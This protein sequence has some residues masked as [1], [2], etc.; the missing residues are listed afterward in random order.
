MTR[1]RAHSRELFLTHEVLALMLGVRRESLSQAANAFQ[2]SGLISYIR[3][4]VMLLDE[5]GLS[6]AACKCYRADLM[7]YERTLAR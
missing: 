5:P 1:D 3:G 2:K 6:T 4:Y 7:V